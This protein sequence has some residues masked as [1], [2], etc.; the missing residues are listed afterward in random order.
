MAVW[1][2]VRAYY[3]WQ[4]KGRLLLRKAP[5]SHI[6]SGE[7][8]IGVSP[9]ATWKRHCSDVSFDVGHLNTHTQNSIYV[10]LRFDF[11][12]SV[13]VLVLSSHISIMAD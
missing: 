11:V 2:Y 10:H 1:L 9:F 5:T 7:G 12:P 4:R 8:P 6:T 3:D 13:L